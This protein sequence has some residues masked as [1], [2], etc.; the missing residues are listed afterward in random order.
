MARGTANATINRANRSSEHIVREEPE[1]YHQNG[2][3]TPGWK[4]SQRERTRQQ[5]FIS[6]RHYQRRHQRLIRRRIKN[7]A[8]HGTH[9]EPTCDVPI[10]L[11]E[12]GISHVGPQ[13]TVKDSF[14]AR[15]TQSLN[16]P[17][18]K[19]PVAHSNSP[20]T[21]QYAKTGQLAIRA[22]VSAFGIVYG[23]SRSSS[24]FGGVGAAWGTYGE[25]FS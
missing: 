7:G 13:L 10:E 16:P 15:L 5:S 25:R 23:D 20:L 21:I 11:R 19:I 14:F 17:A 3:A 4:T 22:S 12:H 8:E 2:C 24:V 1:Q 6:Q 18:T 9:V